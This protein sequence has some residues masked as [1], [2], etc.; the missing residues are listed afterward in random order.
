[1]KKLSDVRKLLQ[2]V[3]QKPMQPTAI[4][5]CSRCLFEKRVRA[6]IVPVVLM[7]AH[8]EREVRPRLV[9]EHT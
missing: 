2:Q 6:D 4:Y 1:M 7:C 5:K 8:C 9:K 3:E